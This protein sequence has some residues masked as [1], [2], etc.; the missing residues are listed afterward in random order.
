MIYDP[1]R[2]FTKQLGEQASESAVWAPW[3]ECLR[4]GDSES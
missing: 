4:A 3:E 2:E 1:S